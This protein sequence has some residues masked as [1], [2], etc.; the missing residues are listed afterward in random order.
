MKDLPDITDNL[1][2]LG[3][4]AYWWEGNGF[5]DQITDGVAGSGWEGRGGTTI[6]D[7]IERFKSSHKG[8][9]LMRVTSL[10]TIDDDDI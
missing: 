3:N 9:T 6:A 4:L 10:L 8:R 1:I 5:P 2:E 7:L